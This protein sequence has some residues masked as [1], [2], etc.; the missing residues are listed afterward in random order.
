ME[1]VEVVTAAEANRWLAV[2]WGMFGICTAI[3][4][5]DKKYYCSEDNLEVVLQGMDF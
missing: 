1:P 3:L 2:V 4:I 5:A